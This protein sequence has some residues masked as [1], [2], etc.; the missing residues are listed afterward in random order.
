MTGDCVACHLRSSGASDIPHVTFTDH[1]I[2]RELPPAVAPED[3]ERV[4]VRPEPFRIV[5][6]TAFP[7]EADQGFGLLEEAVAYFAFY[8][9]THALQAYLDSVIVK[10]ESGFRA[11]ADHAEARLALGR[12]LL[13]QGRVEESAAVLSDGPWKCSRPLRRPI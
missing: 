1:W 8:D 6:A 7:G 3:I 2:R 12:V 9:Q 4:F 5:R 11:G 10:A 13:E